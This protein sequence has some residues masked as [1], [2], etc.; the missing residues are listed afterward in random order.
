MSNFKPDKYIRYEDLP[1]ETRDGQ[2]IE[3]EFVSNVYRINGGKVIQCN[4][5]DI[6]ERYQAEKALNASEERYRTLVEQASDGIFV[7]DAGGKYIDVNSMGCALL[8]YTRE[9]ILQRSM[10]DLVNPDEL[11]AVPFKLSD[12]QAGK[13][14]LNERHMR[15]KDGSLVPVEISGRQLPDGRLLGMV[16]DITE[17]KQ[18][19]QEIKS[20]AR[21]PAE[22]PNP[23]LR[24]GSDGVLL[25]ANE[26]SDVI[27]QD[28]GC[29]V[30]ERV[31]AF[32]QAM[33]AAAFAGQSNQHLDVQLA[34]RI[35]SFFMTPV[36]EAGYINLYG[37]D[38]TDRERAERALQINL[39]RF[40]TI[41]SSLNAGVL[42]VRDEG[43]VEYAN[44]SF[45]DLFDLKESPADLIDLTAA[46]MIALIRPAYRD[47]E[48]EINR[49]GEI[50]VRREVV[51]GEEIAMSHART[52]LRDFIPLFIDGQP[53]GRLW[54]HIDITAR[55]RAEAALRESE[56]R[57]REAQAM[58]HM[59]FWKWDVKTGE[60]EWSEEVFKIFGRAP[61]E[62]TP[63]IDSILAL[64]PWPEDQHRDQ[65][66]ITK[67]L[68]THD[69][70]FYEQKF[71]RP[72][73]S[74]GHYASTFQGTYNE[75][76]DL[77]SIVGTVQ[78]ITERKRLESEQ[79]RLLDI[80]EKSLNEIYV[81]DA[82]TL[83]F[84]YLNHGALNNIGYSLA[85]MQRLTPVEIKPA[86]TEATFRALVQPLLT[87]DQDQLVFE[88][89][90]RRKNGTEYPVEVHLQLITQDAHN[91][92]LSIIND[93]SA[94]Q[95][96]EQELGESQARLQAILD[97]A[98]ALISIKDLQGNVVLANRSFAALDAPPLNDLIGKNVFEIFPH[99]V[100]EQLWNN[101]LAALHAQGPVRSEEIVGHKDGSQHTYVTVKFPIYIESDQPT[102]ICAISTD[103]T[104]R[105]QAEESLRESEDKFKYVF[106]HSAIGKSITQPS[107]EIQVNKAFCEMLGYS[108][109]ELRHKTWQ[110]ISHPAD[111]DLTQQEVD[112]LL[113]GEKEAARFIKRYLHKNGSV[114]WADVRTAL[115]RDQAGNPLYF[116]TAI[117]DITARKQAEF[118]REAALEALQKSEAQLRTILDATPFPIA[119]VD[120]Q[121][122][123]IEFWSR[124]ALDLFGHT[125][126]TTAEW[127]QLAYPDPD[128]RSE[129]VERWKLALEE[130]QRSGQTVN[131]GEYR[132]ACRDGSERICELYA[133][134]LADRL[135]V[136]FNDITE[137]K[138]AEEEIRQRAEEI[139][140]LMEI[141]PVA[142][143]V[144][145]D[146]HC[147]HI[148]GNQAANQF[149][150]AADEENVSAGVTGV[151][152]FFHAGQELA[153][154]ELTMQQAA[155][156]GQ[157]IRDSELDVLLPSGR[158][159]T[160]WGNAT[161]LRDAAGT[162]RG[163]IGAFMDITERKQ[164][165]EEIRQLNAELEQR[166]LA[167]TV[168]LEAANQ[169]L[170]A[171][172]YSISHDLRAPL[173]AID[174]FSRILQE[175]YGPHLDA[176]AQRYLNIVRA[177]A[178]QM[179]HLI[180]DLLTFSRLSRQP[181]RKQPVEM[182]PL[183]QQVLADLQHEESARSV[184]LVVG[185]LPTCAGRPV[186]AE[187]GLDQP[188]VERIQIHGQARGSAHRNWRAS[189]IRINRST[190]CGTTG[191]G[192]TCSMS[193]SC[194][195]CFSGSIG[196]KSTR[197]PAWAWPS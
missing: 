55:Q 193:T 177:N 20:L 21:F 109:V 42:L 128:Y 50:V 11:A 194:L 48:A 148:T 164:A 168:Q 78:D 196:L 134:Y 52:Y 113:R 92:F 125:A 60:V 93:I 156:L 84:E 127:Y 122:N 170:E 61:E 47:P 72:D 144:A 95:Q 98:P 157:D 163:C 63:Q 107:G 19:E 119:L 114:V 44:Q 141:T 12:L 187:T 64:S 137:R 115:R 27:L 131:T 152:R 17:R 162:V 80:I 167:R 5:R 175:E 123:N 197:A 71:L 1:L 79:F 25:Y 54:Q 46:E 82:A 151:R 16:R 68:A 159:M 26:A 81:F 147:L 65:E 136:T 132:V 155:L 8:G 165:E 28:W 124:S 185:E 106:D 105:K 74:I 171:F 88:T 108:S 30:G 91:V 120:V 190:S 66:L 189:W 45:C 87:R 153:A 24:V 118:Q 40:Y 99:A 43:R 7:A 195:A 138:Q 39:Q 69:P 117:V 10:K 32:W 3:V 158:W 183:V 57:L 51:K 181:L 29:T 150:E 76:G 56:R 186:P 41:L 184:E 103:I 145:T 146:P 180:D 161:P 102:G 174:G 49:I 140:S 2:R 178:Q 77:V 33:I 100:A 176:E 154:A 23:V 139:Q 142:I 58:A 13:I 191:P 143:W 38:I 90:H 89:R 172:S 160:I 73:Q 4:V 83:R 62:F 111:L 86:Y 35:W 129:V 85:E 67:A 182:N 112:A 130:T 94:R 37:R 116:M 96:A 149:Y 192:L 34:D 15:R 104:E 179:G 173:R 14:V 6:T 101:D 18:A 22:N 126:P 135:V 166:V 70:G 59:G 31:P 121:D 9:E 169:E 36:I 110:E 97:Y 188:V 75:Q 133:A 53:Y